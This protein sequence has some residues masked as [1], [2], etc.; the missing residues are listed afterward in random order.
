MKIFLILSPSVDNILFTVTLK[1]HHGNTMATPFQIS[2]INL[3]LQSPGLMLTK[4]Y[5]I[6]GQFV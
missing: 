5:L 3:Q 2:K 1:C 6:F 4:L